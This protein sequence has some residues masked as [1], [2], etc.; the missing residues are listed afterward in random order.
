LDYLQS[1]SSLLHLTHHPLLQL[2]SKLICNLEMQYTDNSSSIHQV[3]E[4]GNARLNQNVLILMNFPVTDNWF[5]SSHIRINTMYMA[6]IAISLNQK[7]IGYSYRKLLPKTY[8]D[9]FLS[10]PQCP[11][12]NHS[13]AVVQLIDFFIEK[14]IMLRSPHRYILLLKP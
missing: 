4:I 9:E 11:N 6:N 3:E 14:K 5:P 12:Q 2:L 13:I 7:N 10:L 8:M 1:K